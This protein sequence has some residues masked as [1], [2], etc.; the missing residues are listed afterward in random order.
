M[1]KS[2]ISVHDEFYYNLLIFETR[3]HKYGLCNSE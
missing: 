3:L 1:I 2:I